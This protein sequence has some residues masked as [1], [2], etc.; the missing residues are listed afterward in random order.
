MIRVNLEGD[1]SALVE[2][3]DWLFCPLPLGRP[4]IALRVW[5]HE[6]VK[7]IKN[8]E[9][10]RFVAL[11]EVKLIVETSHHFDRHHHFVC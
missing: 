7:F 5:R 3:E 1:C 2:L 4:N 10:V 8:V 9:G 6:D 11:Y